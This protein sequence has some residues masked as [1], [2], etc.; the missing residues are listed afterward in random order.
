[1]VSATNQ[2]L[3]PDSPMVYL[4]TD[5]AI[6]PGNSGGPLI[7][8]QGEVVG[9]NS[10]I[11]T[12]SGG[13]EGVGFSIPSNTARIV[14]EQLVKYGRPRRGT[15]GVYPTNLT[16]VLAQGLGLSRN[17]GVVI[18][19]V[20]P[21]SPADKAGI[22]IDDIVLSADGRPMRDTKQFALIMFRKRPGETVH[23]SVLRG[24]DTRQ[25]DVTVMQS[26]RDPMTLL[27]P[28]DTEQ[29]LIPRL[30]ALVL[31]ITPELAAQVGSPRKSG[32]LLVVARTF[33]AAAAEVNLKTGDILYYAN[34]RKLDSVADL[35]NFMSGLKSGDAVVLQIERDG[36]LSFLPFRFEE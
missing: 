12:Q 16:P 8:M 36:L 20:V 27:N 28:A 24:A 35:K 22:K 33:S 26:P 10:M 7:D 29:D 32:G 9:I 25:V 18:E 4:Q 34:Q 21:G 13:N 23:L 30:G 15:I 2:Q 17:T 6:N 31:P 19:D 3:D 14:Y 11:E 1:V 5:A